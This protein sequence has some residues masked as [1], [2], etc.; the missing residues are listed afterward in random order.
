MATAAVTG[1][2]EARR[3][4][5]ADR[6]EALARLRASAR[7]DLL[8]LDVVDRVGEPALPG[9]LPSEV[10]GAWRDGRLVGLAALRPSL[11]L[12]TQL[13]PEALH[14]MQET[15][16]RVGVG[17][18]K[19]ALP[20]ADA[21]WGLLSRDGR[22]RALIDRQETAYELRPGSLR[23]AVAPASARVR[24]AHPGDLDALVWAAR[25]SLREE[26]RPDPFSGDPR[27]FRRWVQGR[28]PRASVIESRGQVVFVGYADVRRPEGWLLQ[29]VYTWPEL[30]RR[31]F[32]RAG[33]AALC[34]QAFAAGAEHVQ[35]AVVDGNEG[36]R[37]LYESLGF[38]SFGKLRTVLFT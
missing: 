33:V 9:E 38:R 22:R 6:R 1:G 31:G 28:V 8:L 34:E 36:A 30:R 20:G 35:L 4:S 25:E 3:V 10:L 26:D 16:E 18:L 14:A 12:E 2:V 15:L 17:L 32:A 23:P 21:L 24:P 13:H 11:I 5:V 29:G 37:L 7:D 27:G 19:T